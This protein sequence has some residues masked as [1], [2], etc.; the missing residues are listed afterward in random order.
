MKSRVSKDACN[1][2]ITLVQIRN[3]FNATHKLFYASL[4]TISILN[5]TILQLKNSDF[6]DGKNFY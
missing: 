1:S 5:S 4:K 6:T 2:K 3:Y